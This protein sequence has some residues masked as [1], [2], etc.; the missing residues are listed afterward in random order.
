MQNIKQI[1]N[2]LNQKYCGKKLIAQ[3]QQMN[4]KAGISAREI[5]DEIVANCKQIAN[6]NENEF[7]IMPNKK[8]FLIDGQEST[9]GNANLYLSYFEYD[10]KCLS[11]KNKHKSFGSVLSL[12]IN[13]DK[14]YIIKNISINTKFNSLNELIQYYK[15]QC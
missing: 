7:V 14:N 12:K 8:L 6:V 4:G 5:I 15:S 3:M 1:E 2:E 11:I 10:N 9:I 13:R